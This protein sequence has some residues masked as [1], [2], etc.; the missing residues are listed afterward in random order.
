VNKT[1][2][3]KK[4]RNLAKKTQ[5]STEPRSNSKT[6]TVSRVD[7]TSSDDAVNVPAN[8]RSSTTGIRKQSLT[9]TIAFAVASAMIFVWAYWPVLTELVADWNRVADYSH[10]YLVLPIAL[11]ILWIR[12]SERPEL[13]SDVSNLI[14]LLLIVVAGSM[15]WVAAQYYIDSLAGWS[16][17]IWIAGIVLVLFGWRIWLWALPAIAFLFF[18]VPLPY[19]IET[20][21]ARPLQSTSAQISCFVLQCLLQP[22]ALEGN[23]ILLGD[24]SLEVARACSGLRITLGIAALAYAFIFLF[25]RS[26]W[27]SG[28]IVLCVLPIAVFANSI[29][30]VATGFIYQ[31]GFEEAALKI[32]HDAAGLVILP[33]A[34]ALFFLLL[35]YLDR[36]IPTCES[37]DSMRLVK[38]QVYE[39]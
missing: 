33:V 11:A 12:W 21:V 14:G 36:L 18:M 32:G 29:R 17:P 38:R 28:L 20:A 13:S 34:V 16:I 8:S 31:G 3:K 1:K 2:H 7:V 6:K 39:A 19:S 5:S 25:R 9:W 10:G 23:T 35:I 30:I 26:A 24:H 27:H 37:L 22:A 15:Q 4:K